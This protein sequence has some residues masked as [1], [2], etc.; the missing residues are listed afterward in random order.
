MP[1]FSIILVTYNRA[2]YLNECICSILNQSL[3]NFELIII[4]DGSTDG[5][6]KTINKFK[7]KRILYKYQNNQGHSK[8]RNAGIKLSRAKW[9]CFVDSD[10]FWE[11]QKLKSIKA[12]L[13]KNDFIFHKLFIQ[14][15]NNNKNIHV[16]QS[17][18]RNLLFYKSIGSKI[19]KPI[20]KNLLMFGN[21]IPTSSVVV[22]KKILEKT[23]LFNTRLAVAEDY[24]LW[25]RISL[26]TNNFFFL[27]K[28]LGTYRVHSNSITNKKKD[29]TRLVMNVEK[30]YL[31]ILS[32][33][34]K[35]VNNSRHNYSIARYYFH[36]KKYKKSINLLQNTIYRGSY[37]LKLKSLV[38]FFSIIMVKLF[39]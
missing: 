17:K 38:T 21:E 26:I 18:L 35:V 23:K 37:L 15:E 22:R 11:L 31:K 36:N 33:R 30:Q 1:L 3:S 7:D 6:R 12:H 29:I 34:E 19:K 25:I 10:D 39:K 20:T 32:L 5:T 13:S 4:D 16:K 24:D 27:P 14:I 2:K 8:A 28:N 9:I